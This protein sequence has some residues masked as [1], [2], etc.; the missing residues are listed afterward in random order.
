[1]LLRRLGSRWRDKLMVA[2]A[3]GGITTML[4]LA[5][6]EVY[7]RTTGDLVTLE[8]LRAN[9]LEF[10]A[11]LFSRYAFPQMVQKKR[12]IADRWAEINERGYRGRSFIVPKPKDLVRVV[13]LGGSSVFDVFAQEGRDWPHLAET[14]MRAKGHRNVEVINAGIPGHASF[15]SLGLLFSEI[16]M[17]EPDYVVVYHAW[18][19]I[20]Y[21]RRLNLES[22]LLRIQR[23]VPVNGHKNSYLVSNPFLCSTIVV[24]S[25]FPLPAGNVCFRFRSRRS[26]D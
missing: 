26:R 6:V 10:E 23:P 7:L 3:G 5:A 22:S 12:V 15:D 1:M 13:I 2:L 11:T 24:A 14:Y 18:N 17:F 20:K 16:W 21:F 25:V 4:G 8:A 19:D 9:S